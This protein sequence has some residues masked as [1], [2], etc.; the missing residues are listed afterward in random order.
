MSR[1]VQLDR[2]ALYRAWVNFLKENSVA[3]HFSAFNDYTR[4]KFPFAAITIMGAPTNVTDLQNF[5]YTVDLTVQTDCYIDTEKIMDLYGMDD[6]CGEFFNS[7]GF[8]KNGDSV[9]SSVN[10]TLIKRITSR[11]TLRNFAGKFLIDLDTE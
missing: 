10:G 8:R 4:A 1:T 3:R 11:Y 2:D 5:E 6:A 9:P 7:L